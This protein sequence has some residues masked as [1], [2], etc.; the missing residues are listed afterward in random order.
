MEN[1]KKDTRI[2]LVQ[3]LEKLPLTPGIKIMIEE[4][5][6]GEY[7]DYKSNKYDCGKYESY[8]RLVSLGHQDLANRVRD[9]EFDEDADEED[10]IELR[11]LVP[12]HSW[13]LFGL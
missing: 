12:Q 7:H 1:E 3:E 5:K 9:G 11:K 6:A 4:A 2:H 8:H 10:K 13:K